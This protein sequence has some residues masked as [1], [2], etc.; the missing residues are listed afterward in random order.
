MDS[1]EKRIGYHFRDPELLRQALT[2]VSVVGAANNQ[3]LEF[4]GDAIFG[5]VVVRLLY[6]LYPHEAEGE[7]AE[8]KAALLSGSTMAQAAR[9]LGLGEMLK[10]GPSDQNGRD[11]PSCRAGGRA[12]SAGR[13]A[14]SRRRHGSGGEIHRAALDG[15]GVEGAHPPRN[16]KTVLQEWAQ[17]RGLPVPAYRVTEQS[18]PAHA[19][20]FTIEAAVQGHA[21]A[22]ASAANKRDAERMAAERLLEKLREAEPQHT[23][24]GLKGSAIYV[25]GNNKFV[26]IGGMAGYHAFVPATGT[27]AGW[28]HGVFWV[29]FIV[30]VAVADGTPGEDL[31]VLRHAVLMVMTYSLPVMVLLLLSCNAAGFFYACAA[32]QK[33]ALMIFLA[34]VGVMASGVA[35]I[36]ID[37]ILDSGVPVA[38]EEPILKTYTYMSHG[39]HA[40][41][42]YYIVARDWH[43]PAKTFTISRNKAFYDRARNGKTLG[44]N[45]HPGRL[46]Y[47]WFAEDKAWIK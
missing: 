33:M 26:L 28:M 8:R 13:R 9:E 3:R 44:I 7:L 15:A 45:V 42:D 2:H 20:Q 22:R 1:L 14:V 24:P 16:A 41:M 11:N 38:Y 46:G 27:R 19:P 29:E 36:L 4:L 5:T 32:R 37:T 31:R 25:F 47:E 40:H 30:L 6:D 18:G 21:P 43:D 23:P 10:V 35:F 34:T 39:R 12:G 17:G